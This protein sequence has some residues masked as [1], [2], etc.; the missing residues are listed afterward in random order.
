MSA[1][2]WAC[3]S[4]VECHICMYQYTQKLWKSGFRLPPSPIF[5]SCIYLPPILI[6]LS[7]EILCVV[8]SDDF[9][10]L[11]TFLFDFPDAH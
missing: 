6:R 2:D 8:F 5:L 4:V 9:F 3:N 7:F 11:V 10:F 1:V